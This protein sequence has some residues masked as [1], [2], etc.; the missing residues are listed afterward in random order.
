MTWA[1]MLSTVVSLSTGCARSGHD[2]THVQSEI[3]TGTLN[4]QAD[5]DTP[6]DDDVA[7]VTSPDNS[8]SIF[9]FDSRWKDQHGRD[10]KLADV[11]GTATVI[12]LI[13][14][15]C[16]HTC[17]LIVAS[18]KRVE[19]SVRDVQQDVRFVLVS[20]DPD[21]DTP[22]KLASFARNTKLD[23]SRWTLLSGT[24][25]DIRQLAVTLDVRYQMQPDGEIA[26]TNGFSVID[27]NGH[28]VHVQSGYSDVEQAVARLRAALR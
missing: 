24:N 26:H 7:R 3:A 4:V 2:A 9:E 28:V 19:G 17:P 5:A 23:E 21:R 10:V 16:T 20:I 18:L 27:R 22:D 13:Y 8:F 15:S 1:L 25:A 14:T 6:S 12:A 11:S